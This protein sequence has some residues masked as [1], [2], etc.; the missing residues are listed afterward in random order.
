MLD[1]KN[2]SDACSK[3]LVD[4]FSESTGY[5]IPIYQRSYRWGNTELEKLFDDILLGFNNLVKT[6]EP[7]LSAT[8]LGSVI[9][10]DDIKKSVLSKDDLND[11][12]NKVMVVIDGQ[13]RLTTLLILLTIIHE[14][15]F[16][17]FVK[18]KSPLFSDKFKYNNIDNE[19]LIWIDDQQQN[20]LTKIIDCL[21]YFNRNAQNDFHWYPRMIRAYEDRWKRNNA[22]YNSQIA[23]FLFN[24]VRV[25]AQIKDSWT[26]DNSKMQSIKKDPEYKKLKKSIEKGYFYDYLKDL[27]DDEKKGSISKAVNTFR[28]K[29]NILF[30]EENAYN[31]ETDIPDYRSLQKSEILKRIDESL[32]FPEPVEDILFEGSDTIFCNQIRLLSFA[33]LVLNRICL[34]VITTTKEDYAFDIFESLNTTGSPLTAFETF[35]PQ[36]ID[37]VG[38]ENYKDSKEKELLDEVDCYLK[39]TKDEEKSTKELLISFGNCYDGR[40]LSKTVKYQREFLKEFKNK[41]T[42]EKYSFLRTLSDTAEFYKLFWNKDKPDFSLLSKGR[43]SESAKLCLKFLVKTDT[44]VVVP[45]LTRFYQ[46]AKFNNYTSD[47]ISEFNDVVKAVTAF[48]VLYRSSSLDTDGIDDIFRQL[49]NNKFCFIKSSNNNF[50]LNELKESLKNRLDQKKVIN[51]DDWIN[52]A[53]YIPIYV[54]NKDIARFILLAA[55]DCTDIDPQDNCLRIKGKKELQKFLTE[56]IWDSDLCS[57]IEHIAPQNNDNW[58]E[59]HFASIYKKDDNDNYPYNYIGNLTLL[60][61][62]INTSLSNKCWADKKIIYQFLST[63]TIQSSD[64]MINQFSEDDKQSLIKIKK[65]HDSYIQFAEA[66]SNCN[67]CEWNEDIIIK[68]GKRILELTWE[69]LEPWLS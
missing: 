22:T 19:S 47:S 38:I 30:T 45:L 5:F 57:T 26:E 3:T 63:K 4:V 44:S 36:V 31:N 7:N 27:Q 10:I 11:A 66:I 54:I 24:Y 64:Q 2:F 33:A 1:L 15:I 62:D 23:K 68:R 25:Q 18:C 34:T 61:G 39:S 58:K 59:E 8:F 16:S 17:E 52:K 42:D 13:Q 40:K 53:V 14:R 43:D 51:K 37:T 41:S 49:L 55:E 65:K 9:T 29:L 69:S 28:K 48:F 20:F 21:F 6:D 32:N 35:K 56:D 67:D 46:K 50:S 60:P 12:P